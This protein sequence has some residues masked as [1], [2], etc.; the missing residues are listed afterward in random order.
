MPAPYI[1]IHTYI[2]RLRLN[3]QECIPHYA[4]DIVFRTCFRSRGP[5]GREGDPIA[6]PRAS[7]HP[8]VRRLSST[9]VDSHNLHDATPHHRPCDIATRLDAGRPCSPELHRRPV[10]AIGGG[11]VA[12]DIPPKAR[13]GTPLPRL[14]ESRHPRGVSESHFEQRSRAEGC[15]AR[16]QGPAK[17]EP[18]VGGSNPS[19]PAPARCCEVG[20]CQPED[21]GG[22]PRWMACD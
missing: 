11:T 16:G 13:L 9:Q 8:R 12:C 19:N 15:P 6:W 7:G 18:R 21:Q 17:D 14:R 2:R 5:P 3:C 20:L 22:Q 10:A 4:S 1:H